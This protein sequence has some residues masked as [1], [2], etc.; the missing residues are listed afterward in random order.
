M[1]TIIVYKKKVE[2][3]KL[4]HLYSFLLQTFSL[5]ISLLN[6]INPFKIT[7]TPYPL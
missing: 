1:R 2:Q 6:I 3:R 7:S 4:L 5:Y